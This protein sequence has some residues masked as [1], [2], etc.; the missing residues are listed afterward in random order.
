MFALVRFVEDFADNTLQV[1][2]VDDIE[3]FTPKMTPILTVRPHLF[4]LLNDEK[5]DTNSGY[6]TVQILRLA[7]K[8]RLFYQL[9]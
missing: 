3:D 9:N 5:N 8:L 7:G 2:P 1:I 4:G 6:F